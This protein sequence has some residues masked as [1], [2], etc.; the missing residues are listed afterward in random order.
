MLSTPQLTFLLASNEP[1]LLEAVEPVL[2]TA[3]GHAEIVLSGEVAL[4]RMLEAEPPSLALIDTRLPGIDVGQLLAAARGQASGTH[5]PI[6]LF[7]DTVNQ[8]WK[9]RLE[10]GVID[11]VVPFD[12]TPAFLRLRVEM[13]LRSHQRV[14]ELEHLR[15]AAA[16]SAQTDTL[17][18]V[19][20]RSALLSVLFR[21]TDRVQRMNTQLCVILF[22]VDDFGHWN[23]RLGSAACD[24][25]LMQVVTRVTRL[26]RS[27]DVLGRVGKDEFLAGLPGCSSVNAVL[28]AERIRLEVFSMPFHIAGKAVR[29]SACFGVASSQGRS[30][31]IVLREAEQALKL[32]KEAGPE[33]IKCAADC[34]ESKAA[35]VAFL[36]P[37]SGD[38][39][40]AW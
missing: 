19:Y 15:D 3:G 1:S 26:L 39:L 8:E 5:F 32:A 2:R 20:N 16:M 13:A 17:T 4:E 6:V 21:E 27:Y 36:S 33:S 31:V 25:L 34:P 23:A 38:D 40:L 24:D 11:D 9:D 37:T 22:D 29:L 12:S 10:E 18:G 30:P 14:R 35:P 7:S 28:L